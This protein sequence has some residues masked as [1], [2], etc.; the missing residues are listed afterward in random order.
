MATCDNVL[1]VNST[2]SVGESLF[3]INTSFN[4]LDGGLCD[5]EKELLKLDAFV[6]SL[7]A[8][9]SST[10]DMSFSVAGYFLSADVRNNS[11]GTVKLG[12]D[13][14][15]TT[16]I[17][18]RN[19]RSTNLIDTQ[20]NT[21]TNQQV[22]AWSGT[23]WTNVSL[24]D[25]VGAKILNELGD[26]TLLSPRENQVLKYRTSNSL[27]VNGPD[28]GLSAVPNGIYEDIEVSGVGLQQGRIWNILPGTVGTFELATNSVS[29]NKIRNLSI[30]NDKF[31]N[32]TIRIE[33]INFDV[34]ERN[35]GLNT[36][37]G[38]RF[39]KEKVNSV[40]HFRKINIVAPAVG[41][42][43]NNTLVVDVD[44]PATPP[45]PRGQNIGPTGTNTARLYSS[46]TAGDSNTSVLRFKTLTEGSGIQIQET[47]NEVIINRPVPNFGLTLVGYNDSG[48]VMDNAAIG[49][50][51]AS[52]YPPENFSEGSLCR[53]MVEYPELVTPTSAT[54][55]VPFSIT[56]SWKIV[57]WQSN[58]I[59][60][61]RNCCQTN[62]AMVLSWVDPSVTEI[63]ASNN[64]GKQ[65]GTNVFQGSKNL[66]ATVTV[67]G[68]AEFRVPVPG[69]RVYRKTGNSWQHV[70]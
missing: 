27:W 4:N 43:L 33:K 3:K 51:V 9:D 61:G 31:D 47:A 30:T 68:Q 45:L 22:L 25:E 50:R 8:K 57:T 19:P 62:S 2:E 32:A 18:L 23:K 1:I 52:V 10:I 35:T 65:V 59:C 49:A 42:V 70:G 20:I 15:N 53:V 24:A 63:T 48:Q 17:F 41:Q 69:V 58:C 56:Y 36:G 60:F 14:P 39:F 26:V 6:K 64:N 21:P 37:G 16:K 66:N 40:L 29:T 67:N 11:I 28:E 38:A 44:L 12:V 46:A 55:S 54:V 7:S 34:G 13:I 5:L